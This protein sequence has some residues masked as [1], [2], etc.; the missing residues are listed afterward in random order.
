MHKTKCVTLIGVNVIHVEIK[1]FDYVQ[2]TLN[3][4]KII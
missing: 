2:F 4:Y 1:R 3:L